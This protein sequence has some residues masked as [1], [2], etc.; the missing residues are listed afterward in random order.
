MA[1]IQRNLQE[2][3]L[4]LD[5]EYPVI[6][7][8]GPRGAGKTTMLRMLMELEEA[9]PDGSMDR[10]SRTYVSKKPSRKK[11]GYVSLDD[12]RERDMAQ[13]DPA[14]FLQLHK[15]PLLISEVQY[16]PA[17]LP[18]IKKYV[19]KNKRPGDFWLTGSHL[20]EL[21]E[22]A[23]KE[24]GENVSLLN[25]FPFSL[26]EKRGLDYPPFKAEASS[27]GARERE[28]LSPEDYFSEIW[29]GCVP[30]IVAA[31]RE[32]APSSED[33][34][35][36]ER[37]NEAYGKYLDSCIR[38][39]VRDLG[40]GID[41]I[42]FMR[43]LTA[44]AARAAQVLNVKA[45]AAEAG[46]DQITAKNW[47]GIIANIG[48]V[49]YI[50]PFISEA[51]PRGIKTPKLYFYDTGLVCYLTKWNSPENAFSGA[52]AGTLFENHVISE[53][54]KGYSHHGAFLH[55]GFLR[56]R[57]G[58]EISLILTENDILYPIQIKLTGEPKKRHAS[59]FALIEKEPL[60]RGPG[61][62]ICRCEK[63][64]ALDSDLF[65]VPADFI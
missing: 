26:D 25:L 13:N 57:D 10:E 32:A 2:S 59:S 23:I 14:L 35:S 28:P 48:L 64:K 54:V 37:W 47:L 39:D 3:V 8:S 62:I 51:L 58:A 34:L 24:L 6:L 15:P 31:E 30:Q 29:Q 4:Q 12:L 60:K 53:I 7:I 5:R 45:I 33:G 21:M 19:K 63:I 38:K 52:F 27:L 44:V 41:P 16:A 43:F 9:L 49:F 55:A 17:L 50:H 11:R 42:K 56:D 36:F 1:Y 20:Y 40:G 65:A 46:I 18:H 22:G 61:V